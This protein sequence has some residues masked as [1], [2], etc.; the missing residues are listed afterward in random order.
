[1]VMALVVNVSSCGTHTDLSLNNK[2]RENLEAKCVELLLV[3][4]FSSY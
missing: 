3:H 1:M 4:N 2:R